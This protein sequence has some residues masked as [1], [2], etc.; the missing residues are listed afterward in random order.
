MERLW[1]YTFFE[2]LRVNPEVHP[3]LLTEPPLNP[4]ANRERMVQIMFDTFNTPAMFISTKAVL[5]LYASGRTTGVDINSGDGVTHVTPIYDGI[6]V[7]SAVSR[8]D[9]AG[10]DLTD[11]LTK[12]LT[13]QKPNLLTGKDLMIVS[14]IKES[15]CYVALDYESEMA[16]AAETSN[17]T[18]TYELPDGNIIRLNSERFRCP[19]VLFQ[20]DLIGME[21]D[22][23]VSMTFSSIMKCSIDIRKDMFTNIV[24]SGGST[25]FPGMSER[26]L[27]DITAMVNSATKV[28]VDA[29][30]DRK[31]A[32]WIGGCI[33]SSLASFQE[34][35]I[36]RDEYDKEGPTIVHRKCP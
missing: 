34:L 36:S 13:D 7:Y 14:D 3:I 21:W 30:P 17:L 8:L 16:A 22:G 5:S 31:Y 18:R 2:Q 33:L 25:M 4:K 27:H 6:I 24:L 11:Y 15:L 23:I 29:P 20:P 1:N 28:R 9:V 35:W 19:E 10:R 32:A 12:L 26:M